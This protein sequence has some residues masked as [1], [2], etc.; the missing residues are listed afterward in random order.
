MSG[1]RPIAGFPGYEIG[2]DGV[3]WSD[4]R[5]GYEG[6]M[7][8]RRPVAATFNDKGR[9]VVRLQ[10]DKK[11]HL[12]SVANL[13]LLTWGGEPPPAAVRA[14]L[15]VDFIDGDSSNCTFT[16]LRWKLSNGLT[17]E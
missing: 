9:W 10:K 2:Q 13:V 5:R 1:T 17:P 6:G 14:G 3:V 12:R 16:N 15:I 11:R 4:H 8:S 7:R